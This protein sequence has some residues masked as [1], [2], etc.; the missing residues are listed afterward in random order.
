VTALNGP[1]QIKRATQA[2]WASDNPT[3]L[4]GELGLVRLTGAAGR[5]GVKVG[6]GATV[7]NSLGYPSG[8][9]TP[10]GTKITHADVQP[11]LVVVG[12]TGGTGEF[13]CV[14]SANNAGG[15]VFGYAG[16]DGAATGQIDGTATLGL[17]G[18]YIYGE[19]GGDASLSLHGPALV[20]GGGFASGAGS[21]VGIH[22][23]Y[24][25]AGGYVAHWNETTGSTITSIEGRF[26]GLAFGYAAYGGHIYATQ[27]TALGT[28]YG[29]GA[30][31][32]TSEGWAFGFAYTGSDVTHTTSYAQVHAEARGA[33][34]FGYANADVA[35]P[36]LARIW[37]SA[38]GAFAG[39]HAVAATSSN[40]LITA[41]ALGAFAFGDAQPGESIVASAAGA[42]QFAPGTNAVADSFQVGNDF[43]VYTNGAP[44]SPA[45]G[46]W[47]IAGGYV[48]IRSGGVSVKIT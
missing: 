17:C 26:A 37:A 44:A 14:S 16:T 6:D 47:W 23:S 12:R 33:L 29:V 41:S 5:I 10:P 28:A 42:V 48:Y 19:D 46:A 30:L 21:T 43:H 13:A 24:G 27:G 38:K 20:V 3:L 40:G 11:G 32:R 9:F 39:G 8:T 45:L 22:A 18:G 35:S 25:W 15:I 4:D 1:G 2:D 34:A 31:V 7:A 36:A